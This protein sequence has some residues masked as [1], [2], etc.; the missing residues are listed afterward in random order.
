MH[1]GLRPQ[2]ESREMSEKGIDSDVYT[3]APVL[4]V[5]LEVPPGLVDLILDATASLSP[6]PGAYDDL[7]SGRAWIEMYGVDRA[8]MEASALAVKNEAASMGI[9]ADLVWETLPKEDWAESWKRFFHVLHVSPRV[10]VRPPWEDYAP[11]RDDEVV[12]TIEP[13]MSFGT[14]LHGTTQ[15]CLRFLEKLAAGNEKLSVADFGCGS[16]ILSIAARMLGFKDVAGVDYDAA[17]VRISAENAADNGIADIAFSQCDVLSDDLPK[18]D[19]VVANILAPILIAAAPRI[20]DAVTAA[21]GSALILSGILETQYD[22]VRAAYEALGFGE[23]ETLQ[24]GEWKS[25]LF[26]RNV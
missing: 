18:R 14:G 25:G 22:E 6:A 23:R 3:E 20:A 11:Q 8:A 15:A 2:N 17:A 24:I 7:L 4:R 19:I 1:L 21:P 26:T 16:G 13:G 12:V 10:T 5:R 9:S